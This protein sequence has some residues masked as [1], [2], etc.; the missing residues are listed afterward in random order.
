MS[1]C[2]VSSYL[3]C[4]IVITV[5]EYVNKDLENIVIPVNV[6]KLNHLLQ[7]N[8]YSKEK[9]DFLVQ[10]FR[11]GFE[12]NYQGEQNVRRYAPNLKLRFG[13]KLEIWNKVMTEVQAGRYAGSFED[14]P[15]R[16]FIQSPIGLV[17]KDRGKKTRLIFHLSY[18]K[19]RESVN[20]GI[21]KHLCSV[22]YPDFADEVQMCLKAGK[23]CKIAQSD[24]SMAFRNIPMSKRSWKFLVMKAEHPVT[25]K[26]WY[27]VD[28]CLPFGSS[29]SCAIFQAFSDA[30]AFLVECKTQEDT[31]NY[32]DDYFFAAL[33]K[34][35]CDG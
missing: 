6:Q 4:L 9:T 19:D 17:P 27:F 3:F 15:F 7:Q 12:L 30:V 22:K 8:N 23:G 26:T 13:S 10:G 16:H 14:V 20:S 18:P 11:Q 24:M 28:K 1:F 35:W 29:I 34:A 21:P 2:N 33:M 5:L 31:L 25:G 32:L